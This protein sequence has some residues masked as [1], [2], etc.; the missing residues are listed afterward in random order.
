[1]LKRTLALWLAILTAITVIAVAP[2]G[3]DYT[4]GDW[5]YTVSNGEATINRYYGSAASVTIPSTI[6]GYSVTGLTCWID[7]GRE[8]GIFYG[9]STTSV[10][11]PDS[12]TTIGGWAFR[13]CTSLTGVTIPDGVTSIGYGAFY[14]C[15]SLTSVTIPDGVTTIGGNAFFN[16]AYYNDDA[17][18]ED[19]MLYIGHHLIEAKADISGAYSIKPGTLTIAEDAFYE[20]TSLTS[21]TIP[22]S[23]TMIGGWAFCKCTSLTSVTIPDGVKKIGGYAFYSC[24]SLTSVTIGDSVTTIGDGAFENCSLTSVTIPDSVT[25]IGSEAFYVCTSLTSVTIPDGV[26]KIGGSAF[27][28]CTSLTSVTIGDSVTEIGYA[29]FLSCTSLTSVTI[30]DSVTTIGSYAFYNCSKLNTVYYTGSQSQWNAI[31]IG[32]DNDP[33]KNASKVYN[34]TSHNYTPVVTPPTCTEGGYTTYTC[35]HCGDT[36]IANEVPALGHNY[37]AVVTAPTCL[38]GGCT[39]YTCSICGDSYTA[40]EVPALGHNFGS[41][42][43]MIPAS[44]E[45]VGV[46]ARG[47]T[48]CDEVETRMLAA[49]GH[50]P[51]EATITNEIAATCVEAGGYDVVVTCTGCGK[52]LSRETVVIPATG[53]DYVSSAVTAPTCACAGFT[54]YTCK[55]CGD[56][57]ISDE[58]PALGHSF[59]NSVCTVCGAIHYGD[60]NGDGEINMKDIVLI[61]KYLANFDDEYE[62][63][64]FEVTVGADVN[65]S[66]EVTMKD[67]V[68]LRRYLANYDDETGTSTETLG[69]AS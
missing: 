45:S 22:D 63:S 17:N 26:K 16:T 42:R 11:I 40:D 65:A 64:L 61:R 54:T 21:V 41:W 30:P 13:D 29:A 43:T 59:A 39:T 23:V 18:R 12:V 47:C 31:S 44:C 55:H 53:H 1:M 37:L 35:S 27:F 57:Y 6:G 7:S 14:Y 51:G 15:T 50:S 5:G 8:R 67:I 19:G 56:S 32:S 38:E 34:Y 46:E 10:T 24:T 69:K 68:L 20:R 28:G 48:R 58:T 49:T 60:A 52:E 33:L 9:K 62:T 66:G 2:A 4:S 36:Y 25:T 3:A